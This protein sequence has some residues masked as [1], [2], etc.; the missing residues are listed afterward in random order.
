M[1][2][3]G[4]AVLAPAT[5]V[6]DWVA[7]LGPRLRLPLFDSESVSRL[8]HAAHRLP[9]ECLVVLELRLAP[10]PGQLDL[11]VRLTEAAHARRLAGEIPPSPH[12][13]FLTRWRKPEGP[14]SPS[15]LRAVWCEFDLDRAGRGRLPSPVVC[16]KLPPGGA[17]PR[18][19][20]ERL[21]PALQGRLPTAAQRR[22]LSICLEA[23]SPPA[24][25]LYLF[26]LSARGT[27][28]VRLEIL[29]LEAA[30]IL[31]HLDAVAP[32]IVPQASAAVELLAGAE[33]LHLSYD[34]G[35]R[36]EPRIGIEG[37]FAAQPRREP[38]WG[39][40]FDRLVERGLCAGDKRDAALDWPGHDTF[41]TAPAAWPA[42]AFGSRGLCFR[43]LSHVKVACGPER[44]PEAKVYLACGFRPADQAEAGRAGARGREGSPPASPAALS[45]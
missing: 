9:G 20:V 19:I 34:V 11:S 33:R 32:H 38:R 31:D 6:G 14:R 29:G 35:E 3:V 13:T 1:G 43:A 30:G 37:S 23:L 4:G 36:V 17:S 8:L 15:R 24:F 18:D 27:E 44:R 22:L 45:S 21:V 10:G 41:W 5:R 40:L 16:A 2:A 42:A 12:R 39:R 26:S 7:V 28:A 25:L